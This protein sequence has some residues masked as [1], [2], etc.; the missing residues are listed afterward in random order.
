MR[1][2]NYT[3]WYRGGGGVYMW[4]DIKEEGRTHVKWYREGGVHMWNNIEDEVYTC[5]MISRR[6]RCT[7]VKC[8]TNYIVCLSVSCNIHV[9]R[10]DT[11]TY[12][13]FVMV[14]D[15]P[16]WLLSVW[17]HPS[18]ALKYFMFNNSMIHFVFICDLFRTGRWASVLERH[19]WCSSNVTN[20][21]RS[22]FHPWPCCNQV[23]L[24]FFHFHHRILKF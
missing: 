11:C 23:E 24:L 9:I 8:C 6:R 12:V 18:I 21:N 16:L 10:V 20:I 22:Q 7:H 4:N 13:G 19:N 1:C 2:V 3:I 15:I 14:V 5:E 17:R